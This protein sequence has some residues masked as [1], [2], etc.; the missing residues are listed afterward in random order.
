MTKEGINSQ[1]DVLRKKLK[2]T[3]NP[4]RKLLLKAAI[5]ALLKLL[6][7]FFAPAAVAAKKKTPTIARIKAK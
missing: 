3:S 5:A 1:L 6:P 4:G 7:E 2:N